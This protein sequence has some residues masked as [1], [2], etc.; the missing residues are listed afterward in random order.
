MITTQVQFDEFWRWLRSSDSYGSSFTY[1]GAKAL[2]EYLDD[3]TDDGLELHDQNNDNYD[4][5]GWCVEFTEYTPVELATAIH[6]E[7]GV[8]EPKMAYADILE[9]YRDN[10][11][12][13]EFDGGVIIQ[14]F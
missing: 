2:F 3:A 8:D 6:D 13:I 9:W 12:V 14:E 7:H 11:T 5:I 1:G 4:P 10:T